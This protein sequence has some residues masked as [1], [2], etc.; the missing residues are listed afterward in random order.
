MITAELFQQYPRIARSIAKQGAAWLSYNRD[1]VQNMANDCGIDSAEVAAAIALDLGEYE[2]QIPLRGDPVRVDVVI[3]FCEAD[4]KFVAECV[5]SITVQRHA[6]PV[7]HLAADGCKFPELPRIPA[8]A[9][10]LRYQTPGSWGPYRIT[11]AIANSGQM[12]TEYIAIQD[13]DDVSHPDRLWRQVQTLRYTNAEMTSSASRNFLHAGATDE[14][15][16]RRLRTEP[17]IRPG[18]TYLTVPRGRCVNGTRTMTVELFRRMNG[19]FDMRCTGDF[20]FDNRCRFSGVRIIDDQT[21]LG[22]RR[23][24]T[25]SMTNGTFAMN[26]PARKR[27]VAIV[28]EAL[29]AIERSPTLETAR[30]LGSLDKT[31]PLHPLP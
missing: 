20:Q 27:D 21:V 11:N 6:R 9:T 14:G 4:A 15:A 8:T 7:I 10:L 23:L 26:T 2:P 12:Q 18:K 28:V 3:P 19:F 5:Q 30:R 1:H 31:P 24:H 17:V 16:V 29:D 25:S 13:G 22:R